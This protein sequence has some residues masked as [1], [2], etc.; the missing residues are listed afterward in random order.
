MKQILVN[1]LLVPA[2]FLIIAIVAVWL[3]LPAEAKEFATYVGLIVGAS[4]TR[5]RKARGNDGDKT[6]APSEPSEPAP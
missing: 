4:L 6:P 1:E 5:V 3:L 2:C